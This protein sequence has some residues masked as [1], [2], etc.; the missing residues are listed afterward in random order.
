MGCGHVSLHVLGGTISLTVNACN[1]K[2]PVFF[3]NGEKRF[4]RLGQDPPAKQPRFPRKPGANDPPR[5]KPL[6]KRVKALPE[7][8]SAAAEPATVPPWLGHGHHM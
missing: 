2:D 1:Q 3:Q 8:V 4:R 7:P 6:H 5:R